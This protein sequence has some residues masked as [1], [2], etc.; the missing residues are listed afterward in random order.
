MSNNESNI[1]ELINEI[2]NSPLAPFDKDMYF[3]DKYPE[4]KKNF[5]VLFRTICSRDFDK[6]NLELLLDFYKKIIKQEVTTEEASVDVGEKLFK[7]YVEP[8]KPLMKFKD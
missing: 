2:V 6:K 7:Q 5:E 3:S 4:F 1:V 8:L